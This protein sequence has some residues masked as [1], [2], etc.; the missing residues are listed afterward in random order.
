MVISISRSMAVMGLQK[1]CDC[2]FLEQGGGIEFLFPQNPIYIELMV[3]CWIVSFV[4]IN[5]GG[6][7][8][9]NSP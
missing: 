4:R 3:A 7:A 9:V 5:I 6:A 8:H 1:P 2:S